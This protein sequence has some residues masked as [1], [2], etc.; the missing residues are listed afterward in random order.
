MSNNVSYKRLYRRDYGGLRRK[1]RAV[2]E[3]FQ[4]V[5]KVATESR[6]RELHPRRKKHRPLAEAEEAAIVEPIR[7]EMLARYS[8]IREALDNAKVRRELRLHELA[9][10]VVVETGLCMN[11]VQTCSTSEYRSQTSPDTYAKGSL[12]PLEVGLRRRGAE[13]HIRYVQQWSIDGRL[14]PYGWVAASSGG[15]Y[16]LWANVPA[17]MADAVLR[18]LSV[19]EALASLP[20]TVNSKVLYPFLDDA[21]FEKQISGGYRDYWETVNADGKRE[22]Y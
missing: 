6:Q 18:S 3:E 5:V 9:P 4:D 16:E 20:Q 10:R 13:T 17:W 1:L 7:D 2:E 15:D 12:L 19:D 8:Y 14:G 21:R 22:A 11:R